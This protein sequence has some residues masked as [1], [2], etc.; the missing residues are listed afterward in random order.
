M[1][2]AAAHIIQVPDGDAFPRFLEHLKQTGCQQAYICDDIEQAVILSVYDRFDAAMAFLRDNDIPY[3]NLTQDHRW[4]P[5]DARSASYE[6]IPP[7]H[8]DVSRKARP[9][10][11]VA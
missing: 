6:A 3:N 2:Y 4:V 11:E 9:L 10:Q 1:A 7:L 5:G 8:P